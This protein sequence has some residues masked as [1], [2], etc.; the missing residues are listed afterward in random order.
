MVWWCTRVQPRMPKGCQGPLR[1]PSVLTW[2]WVEPDFGRIQSDTPE[3]LKVQK[4]GAPAAQNHLLVWKMFKMIQKGVHKISVHANEAWN[5]EYYE[6]AINRVKLSGNI[7]VLKSLTK[8]VRNGLIR[9]SQDLVSVHMYWQSVS[10]YVLTDVLT[11]AMNFH[12]V[13]WLMTSRE[14][15]VWNQVCFSNKITLL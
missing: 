14:I 4:R 11:L 5:T 12:D 6:S 3:S 10:T 13:L 15:G 2:C 9:T 1:S 8:R 7:Q